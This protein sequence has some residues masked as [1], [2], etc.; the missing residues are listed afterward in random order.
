[1]GNC[2]WKIV[3]DMDN[4]DGTPTCWVKEINHEKYGKH[5]WISEDG[6]FNVEIEKDD[7]FETLVTCK[8]LT[9]AKR[10]VSTNL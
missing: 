7:E 8:T 1:M 3:H 9:S 4:D 10:W 5:V 6:G 2:E